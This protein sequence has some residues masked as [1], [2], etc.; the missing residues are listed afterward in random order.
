MAP[1]QHLGGASDARTDQFSFCV[2][3][4][5]ALYG[6]RPFDGA[7]YA[8]LSTNIIKGKVRPAPAGA[9]VPAWLRAVVLRG[10]SVA[11]DRRFP[12]MDAILAALADDPALRGAALAAGA[13]A[14]ALL[15][16]IAGVAS[17][18]N[19]RGARRRAAAP[20]RELGRRVGRRA[21]GG[22]ARRVR[23]DRQAVRRRRL[24]RR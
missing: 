1:E 15:V 24:R 19:L 22:R 18:R 17:W 3:F 13:A 9:T 14:V 5:Q 12:S 20:T 16:G 7:N 11:P 10:L 4:Y 8:E 6:E 21:Q 2:A 23:Q